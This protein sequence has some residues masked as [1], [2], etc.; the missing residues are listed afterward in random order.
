[1]VIP[2]ANQDSRDYFQKLKDLAIKNELLD[3]S[4]GMSNDYMQAVISGSTFIRIGSL[5]FKS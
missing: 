3:L 2:P 4:M 1:M 5:I